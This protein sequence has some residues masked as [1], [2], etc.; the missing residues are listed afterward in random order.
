MHDRTGDVIDLD[1]TGG[2]DRRCRRGWLGEDA[3]GR[4]IPCLVCRPHLARPSEVHDIDDRR[5]KRRAAR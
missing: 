4:P 2:H 3:E 5:W 1:A